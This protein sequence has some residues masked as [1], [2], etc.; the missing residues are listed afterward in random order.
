M[1]RWRA[2]LLGRVLLCH[3]VVG[4][5]SEDHGGKQGKSVALKRDMLMVTN[6]QLSPGLHGV[7]NMEYDEKYIYAA[8]KKGASRGGS[9][10]VGSH[11]LITH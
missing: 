3:L 1:S 10:Q 6:L 4:W 5:W 11:E 7:F 2:L 8:V 9:M